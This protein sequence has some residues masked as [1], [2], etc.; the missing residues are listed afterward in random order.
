ML[1]INHKKERLRSLWVPMN[2][3]V[4]HR[5]RT[6]GPRPP[7]AVAASP[8]GFFR[9]SEMEAQEVWSLGTK[10]SEGRSPIM[11]GPETRTLGVRGGLSEG[12]VESLSLGLRVSGLGFSPVVLHLSPGAPLQ[13][14]L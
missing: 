11:E 14:L 7:A 12:W 2:L 9:D 6:S 10:A 3:R 1:S 8:Q 5:R 4:R 13:K